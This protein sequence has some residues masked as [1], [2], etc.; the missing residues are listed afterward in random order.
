MPAVSVDNVA[1]IVNG[2]V[3]FRHNCRVARAQEL[4]A[5]SLTGNE[6]RRH[7]KYLRV[8]CGILFRK[9]VVFVRPKSMG[10]LHSECTR[11]LAFVD[12]SDLTYCSI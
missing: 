3:R 2:G 8:G 5:S 6:T 9:W 10:W 4:M 1:Q 12:S 7:D 11:V